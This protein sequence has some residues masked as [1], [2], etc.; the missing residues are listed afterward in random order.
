MTNKE[1]Q[2]LLNQEPYFEKQDTAKGIGMGGNQTVHYIPIQSVRKTLE[3]IYG[4]YSV[5]IKDTIKDG[6]LVIVIVRVHLTHPVTKDKFF[7]DGIGGGAFKMT[8][9]YNI[10]HAQG[11]QKPPLTATTAFKNAVQPLGKV[12]GRDLNDSKNFLEQ[13]ESEIEKREF[14]VNKYDNFDLLKNVGKEYKGV[15]ANIVT[16]V[17]TRYRLLLSHFESAKDVEIKCDS[18]SFDYAE[19]KKQYDVIIAEKEAK[20]GK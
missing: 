16:L 7:M 18:S 15:N 13:T 8:A 12:F 1:Y 3:T 17:A 19:S 14:D 10:S 20:N 11:V 4:S 6:N 2:S 9:E 5:E